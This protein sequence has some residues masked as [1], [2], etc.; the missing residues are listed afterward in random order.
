MLVR[1][2]LE[3]TNLE[4]LKTSQ[5]VK[6]KK[7]ISS[8]QKLQE[9]EKAAELTISE[10]LK[11]KIGEGGNTKEIAEENILSAQSD[12][13]DVIKADEMIQQANR[14]I[15]NQADDAIKVQSGQ[16]AAVAIELLK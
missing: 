4:Y 6:D 15:L 9:T 2:G 14:N 13:L 8:G 7:S 16:T 1:N 11:Q 5:T 12:V 3:T 10:N